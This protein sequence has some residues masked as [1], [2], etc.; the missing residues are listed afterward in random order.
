MNKLILTV[1]AL[2]AAAVMA[3]CSS[4]NTADLSQAARPVLAQKVAAAP[5]A[6]ASV[7]S[8]EVRARREA[9]LGF[10]IPGKIVARSVDMGA[11]V[12]KGQVLARIDPADTQMNAQ[13]A[14]AAAEAAKTDFQFASAEFDRYKALA[15]KG[16]VSRTVLDQKTSTLDAARSRLEQAQA[17]A[18]LSRNQVGYTTLVADQDG[19]ITAVLAEAGQVVSAGQPVMRLARPEEKEV[20][21][22]I[23]EARIG[24]IRQARAVAVRLAANPDKIYQG[25]VRELAP[26]ADA[27]TRSFA[28]RVSIADAD[29]N[30]AL[31]M[32]ASVLFV[33]GAAASPAGSGAVLIP[34]TALSRQGDQPAV[35]VINTSGQAQLRAVSIKQ[36]REDGILV[37]QGLTPGEVIA[38]AGVHKLVPGQ[39]VHPVF[40]AAPNKTAQAQDITVVSR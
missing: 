17:Q 9:D 8:G 31:G 19:V 27:V 38:V 23:P 2:A 29:A 28:A 40:E 36:Y 16:F 39:V 3:A 13:A 34:L 25:R 11:S 1:V 22:S 4:G 21:I 30:V 6:G 37:G 10:R 12:K 35:W 24:Q 5:E 18:E 32:T 7:Y 20:L 33:D 26:S 14:R 15:D